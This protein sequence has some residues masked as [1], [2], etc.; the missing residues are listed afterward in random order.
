MTAPK[1]SKA[2]IKAHTAPVRAKFKT[3]AKYA[4]AC[5]L[6][7]EA[8]SEFDKPRPVHP[9]MLDDRDWNRD[10][11]MDHICNQIATTSRG[12][13]NI[14][15]AG[16]EGNALPV[17]ST[18]M[19]W[20]D[21]DTALSDRYTRAKEAQADFMADEILDIADDGTNDWMERHDKDGG[22]AGYQING[23]HVQRSR[24]R[25]ESRKWLAS[26][27]KPKKYG[28]KTTIA[29]DPDSPI[30]MSLKVSFGV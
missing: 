26:K 12:I 28:E 15:V 24:L 11:V 3:G 27:L 9:L 18:V 5:R 21:E 25:I 14:L 30:E 2:A 29:G 8:R 16:Y 13:G 7:N 22:N 20:I 4:E 1:H 17:Y 6:V 23:E 10:K 19:K